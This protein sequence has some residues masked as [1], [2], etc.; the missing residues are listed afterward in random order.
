MLSRGGIITDWIETF[1]T[2]PEGAHVGERFVLLPF[3]REFLYEVYNGKGGCTIAK[4]EEA[5]QMQIL[6]YDVPAA[7]LA[8]KTV[9]EDESRALQFEQIIEQG[10]SPW[11]VGILAACVCQYQRLELQPH[12]HVPAHVALEEAPLKGLE[13]AAALVRKLVAAGV[14]RLHPDPAAAYKKATGRALF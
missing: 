2:V 7:K 3:Q 5:V 10:R 14:S 4:E 13:E 8:V 11:R 1:S 6:C 9:V 12:Q